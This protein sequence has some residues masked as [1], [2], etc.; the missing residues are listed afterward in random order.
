MTTVQKKNG[1]WINKKSR[2]SQ[3]FTILSFVHHLLAP[4]LDRSDIKNIIIFSLNYDFMIINF[5][6]LSI[7]LALMSLFIFTLGSLIW[8]SI[9]FWGGC[10]SQLRENWSS[11]TQVAGENSHTSSKGVASSHHR[12]QDGSFPL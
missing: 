8:S 9:A 6:I 5:I 3:A 4:H 11:V 12:I 1:I 10:D 2:N 7:C